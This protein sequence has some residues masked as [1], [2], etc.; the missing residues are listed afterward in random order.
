MEGC[1]VRRR[2]AERQGWGVG[3]KGRSQGA[4]R[5]LR[6]VVEGGT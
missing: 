3:C 5:L 6:R 2:R 1:P 4:G